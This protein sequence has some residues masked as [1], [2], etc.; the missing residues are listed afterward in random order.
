MVPKRFDKSSLVQ[1][2]TGTRRKVTS[3]V[4]NCK[5]ML[6]DF[7]KHANLNIFPL[8]SYDLLIGMDWIDEHKI[9]LNCFDK[10]FTCIDNNI[11]NI[12]DKGISRKVTIREIYSLQMKRSVRK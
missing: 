4:R 8:V 1:L 10:T 5:I 12:K 9:L 3:I 7:L 2:D 6:N 11:N